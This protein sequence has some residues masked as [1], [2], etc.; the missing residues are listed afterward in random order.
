MIEQFHF[1]R[2]YW[3]MALLPLIAIIFLSWKHRGRRGEW[4]RVVDEALLPHLISGSSTPVGKR[5]L[6]LIAGGG[7]I[8]ILALAG[9]TWDEWPQPLYREQSTLVI[10]LDLSQSMN[11]A[12]VKPS[13]LE[14]AK[15]KIIDLLQNRKEGQTALLV[16]AADAFVV[17]PLSDDYQTLEALLPSLS[18]DIMPAQG[19]VPS[20]A[21][22]L[23]IQ[24]QKNAGA[25]QGQIL[26]ITDG[27]DSTQS[28]SVQLL[29]EAEEQY[30]LSVLATGTSQGGPI[31]QPNGGFLKDD[32]GAIIIARLEQQALNAIA[33]ASGG[34][35]QNMTI[36]DQD[37]N[38]LLQSFTAPIV[39]DNSEA[40]DIEASI[41]RER[42]PWLVLLLLPLALLVFRRGVL[43]LIPLILM[44]FPEQSFAIDW[45]QLWTNDNQKAVEL[46][47]QGQHKDAL[48]LLDHEEWK[49]SA[50][51]QSGD[52]EAAEK[53]WQSG[54]DID[55]MYNRANA[56]AKLG[57][58]E[59][60]LE[61]YNKVL[62]VNP[63]HEDAEYNRKAVEE[64][65]KQQQQQNQDGESDQDQKNQDQQNQDQQDGEQQD[66]QSSKSDQQQQSEQNQS[67]QSQEENGED[68]SEPENNQQ[69][70]DEPDQD[71]NQQAEQQQ[72][73]NEDGENAEA[74]EYQPQL[75]QEDQMSE[76]A[77]EQWLRKIPDDPGGLLRRKFL[78]QY[79]K[80]ETKDENVNPW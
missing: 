32:S 28:G 49:A 26:L 2:P 45:Q 18:T 73:N 69:Q 44:P 40:L 14:R 56:L 54:A 33:N 74:E 10:A 23:A 60:A 51:Y 31:P 71:Q 72:N 52:Y 35:Y 36:G 15:R 41:W 29:L 64:A 12:D 46:Y 61:N 13:R 6:G 79:G 37:I 42:G 47:K 11:V 63:E 8:T 16:F 77:L 7:V 68:Q 76:Q 50:L 4:R 58:L 24:L 30:R 21:I 53:I 62:E 55:A 65:M 48:E 17:M 70:N 57:K 22:E 34:V 80:R 78:Y 38:Q 5:L 3:L 25:R 66:Q 1:I 20:R 19:S 27:I 9:P 59:E 75:S 43:F 67:S 39:S